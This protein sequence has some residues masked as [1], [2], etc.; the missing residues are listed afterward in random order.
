MGAGSRERSALEMS[1]HLTHTGLLTCELPQISCIR[2]SQDVYLKCIFQPQTCR[3]RIS[4][5]HELGICIL[6]ASSMGFVGGA[7]QVAQ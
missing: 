7:S 2:I 5:H 6:N 1:T 3:L 4:K